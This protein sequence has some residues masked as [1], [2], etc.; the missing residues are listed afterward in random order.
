MKKLFFVNCVDSKLSAYVIAEHPTEAY[1][2][3]KKFLDEKAWG[4]QSGRELESI[5]LLAE[6]DDYTKKRRILL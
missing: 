5:E 6:D 2:K 4:F 1:E 3:L